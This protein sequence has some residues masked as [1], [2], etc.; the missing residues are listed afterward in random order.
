MT[1]TLPPTFDSP[2]LHTRLTTLTTD[3][4]DGLRFGVIGI[5]AEHVVRRYNAME[6]QM[7]GLAVERVMGKPFFALVAVCMNNFMVAQRFV[8]AAENGT[9]LDATIDYVLTFRMRPNKVRLRLLAT[10]GHALSYVLV[11]RS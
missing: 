11:D 1:E 7:A 9:A 3:E 6:S 2:G 5:D 10:P 8:D 4:I